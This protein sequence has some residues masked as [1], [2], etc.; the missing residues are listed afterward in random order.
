MVIKVVTDSTPPRPKPLT[1]KFVREVK[2]PGRYGDGWGSFGLSLHVKVSRK[3]KRV[4]KSWNQRLPVEAKQKERGL[5]PYPAVPLHLARK[6]AME[7]WQRVKAG[8]DILAAHDPI[9]T[10]S[11]AFD[12]LI[13]AR[14]PGWTGD[15]TEQVWRRIQRRCTPVLQKPVSQVTTRDVLE[16][17]TPLWHT[18][19]R[20][21]SDIRETLGLIMRWAISQGYRTT[22]PS[23]PEI[24]ET[25]GKKRPK[26]HM[27]S[28]PFRKLGKVLA[29]VRDA[30]AWWATICCLLFLVFTVARS[31]QARRVTW[32]EIDFDTATWTIPAHRM[33]TRRPHE[34]PLA[35]QVIDLLIYVQDR[36]GATEGLIFPPA[37]DAE[38]ISARELSNLLHSVGT[39]AVP[40]GMRSTFRNWAGR[41]PTIAD[42]V[43][44]KAMAHQHRNA[45]AAAYLNDEYVEEREPLMQDWADFICK[46]MGTLIPK[47][48]HDDVVEPRSPVMQEWAD[49]LIDPIGHI[50]P[51]QPQSDIPTSETK[52]KTKPP[53]QHRKER[54]GST[55]DRNKPTLTPI[56]DTCPPQ[57]SQKPSLTPEDRRRKRK[58]STAAYKQRIKDTGRCLDCQAPA[59]PG[60]TRCQACADKKRDEDRIRR[61]RK[62]EAVQ[63]Q[64]N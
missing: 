6:L 18:K 27:P 22:N 33:K 56:D 28:L 20:T 57:K 19:S 47:E 35:S 61:A 31:K 23:L 62:R 41:E 60:K 38:Y 37:R 36:T 11:E 30:D 7:N 32:E 44:E 12:T 34:V 64:R 17:I 55:K 59:R 15:T 42:A 53:A 43:A 51:A 45:V 52:P 5:G 50:I 24:T 63:Q 16:I 54:D 49:L 25:L 4:T 14:A 8:E 9:P 1:P 29:A 10:V 46:T 39:T 40:H 58:D 13:K 2:D 21:A 26:K 48:H 3:S